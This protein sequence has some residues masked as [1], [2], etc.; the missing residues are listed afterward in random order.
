MTLMSDLYSC[1]NFTMFFIRIVVTL[2]ASWIHIFCSVVKILQ[3]KIQYSNCYKKWKNETGYYK[4]HC[5]CDAKTNI[6][7]LLL[8]H[9]EPVTNIK[10]VATARLTPF[11]IFI[12]CFFMSKYKASTKE[13]EKREHLTASIKSAK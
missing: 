12:L 6:L 2:M 5:I 4:G 1:H 13:D 7:L 8:H 3:K 9:P 11:C 10:I